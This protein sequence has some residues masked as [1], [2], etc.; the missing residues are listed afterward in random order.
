MFRALDQTPQDSERQ[1]RY[2]EDFYGYGLT[3][4]DPARRDLTE[5]DQARR[6]LLLL[7]IR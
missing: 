4:G 1:H 2:L 7:W 3:E 5:S 6:M